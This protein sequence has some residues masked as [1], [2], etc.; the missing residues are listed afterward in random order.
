MAVRALSLYQEGTQ[1]AT[2]SVAS[3]QLCRVRSTKK[4]YVEDVNEEPWW[5]GQQ[6]LPPV[7]LCIE[8]Q[9]I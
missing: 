2:S 4:S 9:D 5:G 3:L 7:S 8:R 6:V 1:R